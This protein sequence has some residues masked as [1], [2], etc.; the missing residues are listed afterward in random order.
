MP[1]DFQFLILI[2]FEFQSCICCGDFRQ[3][4]S[5]FEKRKYLSSV[6]KVRLVSPKSAVLTRDRKNNVHYQKAT[7]SRL[8]IDIQIN[9]HFWAFESPFQWLAPNSQ[10]SRMFE[11]IVKKAGNIIHCVFIPVV[12]AAPNDSKNSSSDD[13]F[14]RLKSAVTPT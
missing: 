10:S 13:V 2:K 3:F 11:G 5:S 12:H 14:V 4:N 1:T 7:C 8:Q 6:S 9:K